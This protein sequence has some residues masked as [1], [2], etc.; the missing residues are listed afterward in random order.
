[1]VTVT[2]LCNKKKICASVMITNSGS[3]FPSAKSQGL[4]YL[5]LQPNVVFQNIICRL[6]TVLKL[7]RKNT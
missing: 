7:D 2:A 3:Q 5:L 1:M 6:S 4:I